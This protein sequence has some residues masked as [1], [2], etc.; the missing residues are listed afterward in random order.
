MRA[1]RIL[2]LAAAL[3]AA[4]KASALP[5]AAPMEKQG[6]RAESIQAFCGPFRCFAR[7]FWRYRSGAGFR[8]FRRF[9]YPAPRP[10]FAPFGFRRFDAPG[11][12]GRFRRF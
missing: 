2:V 8:P 4:G 12:Y 10:R 1:L 5:V 7:P 6:L 9:G 3:G 11:G